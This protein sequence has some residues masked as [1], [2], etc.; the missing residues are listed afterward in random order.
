[1]DVKGTGILE[2]GDKFTLCEGKHTHEFEWL[3]FDRL[4]REYFYPVF[5]KKMIEELPESFTL[6]TERE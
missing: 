5:L 1:M 4:E 6:L 3:E 2:R